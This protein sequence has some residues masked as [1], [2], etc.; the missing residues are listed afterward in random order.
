MGSK[1]VLACG[2]PKRGAV[3]K[4]YTRY[5]LDLPADAVHP[6]HGKDQAIWVPTLKV[7]VAQLKAHVQSPRF[8]AVVDSGSPCCVFK[9]DL[10]DY[11]GIDLT[12]GEPDTV[13]GIIQGHSETIYFHKVR[14]FVEA[15]WIIEVKAG[16]M[17]KL[18]VNGILG[19]NGFFDRFQV[20]FDHSTSP[21]Q[22]EV[23]RIE[24]IN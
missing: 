2:V 15:D 12:K 7:R 5:P 8:D 24:P 18:S 22:L 17:K 6:I 1:T 13:G 14:I 9:A 11:L 3:L 21:H 20:R 4:D 19:R 16:F 10:A 23:N